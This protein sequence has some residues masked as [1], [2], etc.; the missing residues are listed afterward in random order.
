MLTDH[1]SPHDALGTVP[2]THLPLIRETIIE[3]GI[4]EVI[5]D[6]LPK[7]P[8][9]NVSDAHC[10]LAL[11]LNIFAPG[12]RLALVHIEHWL[13]AHDLHL[14]LGE[15]HFYAHDFND[16]RLAAGFDHIF[17]H[18][19]D[20]ILSR[21]IQHHLAKTTTEPVFSIHQDT[22]S[23]SLYGL[24]DTDIDDLA[25]HPARGHSKDRRPDLKQLI[26]G[27]SLQAKTG[28]PLDARVMDGNLADPVA[29][30]FQLSALAD[31]LP[32]PNAVTLVADCKLVDAR[33]LGELRAHGFH[34]IS[35]LPD[36]FNKRRQLINQTLQSGPMPLI[37]EEPGR[38]KSSS[39]RQWRGRSVQGHL[40]ME[41]PES[42][43]RQAEP[44][45]FLVVHS[46]VLADK[47]DAQL[48]KRLEKERVRLEKANKALCSQCFTCSSDAEKAVR[49]TP[50]T[51][52]LSQSWSV[53]SEE[54]EQPYPRAGRPPKGATRPMVTRYRLVSTGLSRDEEAIEE[55]RRSASHFVLVTDHL[56]ESTW[57]DVALDQE[58]RGQSDVEGHGGFRWLKGGC[59]LSPVFLHKPERIA[60]LGLVFVLA[61]LVRNHLQHTLRRR[62]SETESELRIHHQVHTKRPTIEA[63]LKTFSTV[64]LI[65]VRNA[66]FGNITQRHLTGLTPEARQILSLLNISTECFYTLPKQPFFQDTQE[67][68]EPR[69]PPERS[70]TGNQPS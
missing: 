42:G 20:L 25:P 17:E 1:L 55:A 70:P 45:R 31:R 6:L 14:F 47:F 58:Y 57:S 15:G 21:V 36:S 52:W 56:D 27:L 39:T 51:K 3:L 34:F 49:G 65:V 8:N 41:A 29:N 5:D 46:S 11:L 61:L 69:H 54:V 33:T 48:D 59:G 28:I 9:Q 10:V 30:R 23:I 60:A 13:E 32:D 19:T 53:S 26:F 43:E 2:V 16:D 67:A 37:R 66:I 38:R 24:Y 35:L 12:G 68:K 18:G 44:V 62:L 50:R 64:G 7:R 22:T 40:L 63:A 4:L